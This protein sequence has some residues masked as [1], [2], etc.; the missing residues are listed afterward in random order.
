MGRLMCL[1]TLSRQTYVYTAE[2]YYVLNPVPDAA[3]QLTVLLEGYWQGLQ[4]PMAFFPKSAWVMMNARTPA[5]EAA[6]S[7]WIGNE[8]HQGEG[9]KPEHA[10]LY[11]GQSP[12]QTQE[13]EFMY[14]AQQIFGNLL[15][16]R[17]EL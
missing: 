17:E 8:R 9:V 5:I 11:R 12:L 1:L 16:V 4:R 15:A 3:E 14:W 7:E 13:A 10:L 6:L 2:Q